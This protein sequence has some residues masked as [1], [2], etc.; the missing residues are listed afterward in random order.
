MPAVDRR[1]FLI[2]ALTCAGA[3]PARSQNERAQTFLAGLVLGSGGAAGRMGAPGAA[4]GPPPAASGGAARFESFW[5]ACDDCSRLGVHYI[6]VNNTY[7]QIM[8]AYESRISEFRDELAKRGLTLL[9]LAVYSHMHRRAERQELIDYHL[10]LARF[11][12]SVGGTYVAQLLAPGENL[13]NADDES[14]RNTDLK[15]TIASADEVGKRMREETGT[16]IG[17]HPEQGDIRTGIY[18][19]LLDSTDARYFGFMPD[20][21]HLAACGLDPI[22]IYRKYRSRMIGTHLRDFAP[23]TE[24]GPGGQP[25]RGRMVPFGT[26]TIKLPALVESLRETKFAGAVMAEGGGIEAVRDYM[27]GTLKIKL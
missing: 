15:A 13:G 14:Y 22:E 3:L 25:G 9:G 21:G 1:G 17:Y 23:A 18:D 26:G 12:Q 5:R 6:E 24:P 16:R 2:G 20:I 10:R 19:R 11:L 4:G 8:E 7:R 27:V